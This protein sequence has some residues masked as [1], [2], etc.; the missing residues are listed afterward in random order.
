[1]MLKNYAPLS[2]LSFTLLLPLQ[3]A[4]VCYQAD[5][6]KLMNLV[7]KMT[8]EQ[9]VGQI[10]QPDLDFITP[11][12]M[13]EYQIGTVLN[14]GNTS[15]NKNQYASADEWK[16][17]SKEFY[18][19]SPVVDGQKIPFLWGTDA[20]HG[21]NNLIGAT[22]FPHNI[23]LGATRNANLMRLIGEAVALEVLS[24]GVTWTFAPALSVPRNDRWGRTYEGF[25]EDPKI[26]A[27][28]GQAFI[29]GLQGTGKEFLD[30]NH[31]L[32]T[33]K[34]FAGDGG[35]N[36][37]IDQGD[38]IISRKLFESIH[39]SPYYPAIDS[40][41]QTIMSSFN[42]FQGKK[43]H[44]DKS[45]LTDLL[46][47]DMKFDGFIIGD[48]NG[49]G[50]VEG[51]TNDNCPESFNAGVD[52]FMAPDSWK[53]LYKNLI[54]QAKS[55]IITEAR[56]NEA[57][58]RVLAVKDRLG[59]LDQRKPHEFKENY[60]GAE[61]HRNI[62][63]QA[64]RESLVLLKNNNN[65]LP[66]KKNINIGVIGSAAN[67]I[68]YQTGGWT[69]D[70]QGKNNKNS[71]FPG[72]RSLFQSMQD[73]VEAE[74]GSVVF[75]NDGRFAIKPDVVVSVFG[76]EP[77]AEG[78][79]DL[80][81]VAFRATDQEHLEALEAVH[82]S[83]I[84][85]VS[86]LYS[87]RPL[88]VNKYLNLSEAFVAAW[89][90]GSEIDGISEIIFGNNNIN[91]FDF[92]GRLAFSWPKSKTQASLN[93]DDQSYDP[94]FS[95][96]YGLNYSVNSQVP[97][98][99][100]VEENNLPNEYEFFRGQA[101]GSDKE[102]VLSSGSVEVVDS[103]SFV[104]KDGLVKTSL[105]QYQKQDDS[106]MIDFTKDGISSFVIKGEPLNIMYLEN[107]Y[108]EIVYSYSSKDK[109]ASMLLSLGCGVDCQ[110][111][112]SLESTKQEWLT[113]TIPLSCFNSNELDKSN[114]AIR[115]M[116]TVTNKS[117]LKLHTIKLKSLSPAD[118]GMSC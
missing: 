90:P 54:D 7:S 32:A 33:A 79:G 52:I 58:T 88:E 48:W 14:G 47:G 56:L 24:T 20:V 115:S 66:L 105:F 25:S 27:E 42:S 11:A 53:S 21:H 60:L 18:D 13:R 84:P 102:F 4:D 85:I 83:G 19:A 29:E 89:L 61:S 70:W 107:P 98:I 9:K 34:H 35:T 75:S 16:A 76:E 99:P 22:I 92:T 1:M 43:L 12:E 118:R 23:G 97:I 17:V 109:N 113:K 103:N 6:E 26:V 59:L 104:S 46:K 50:Q 39:V 93:F 94:L 30:S 71:D 82:A 86:I 65:V 49:H 38:V 114:I 5:Q 74:G 77:Y 87:G 95:F 112:I 80:P 44:G 108:L 41:T 69:L 81:D 73:F 64:V 37:G 78:F 111:T 110:S 51:C 55:S 36:E 96:G 116:F 57:V 15:P 40:C 2:L 67:E 63:R 8:L 68:R 72:V 45:M 117:Q 91:N 3:A 10:V 31:I 28:L 100:L 101:L 62:A 106:K